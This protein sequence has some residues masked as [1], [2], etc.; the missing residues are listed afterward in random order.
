LYKEPKHRIRWLTAAELERLIA[1]LPER[2]RDATRFAVQTG[3]RQGNV[4]GLE[5]AQVDLERTTA[6]VHPDQAKARKA[7]GV[8]LSPEAVAILARQPRT[9]PLCF[10]GLNRPTNAVWKRALKK[11]SLED[12][13][14][15][16][17]RHTWA[18]WH[19]QQG[20]PLMALQ[21]L[22]GWESA[23]MVK[24]Y[25]HLGTSHLAAYVQGFGATK[26]TNA[27]Q[28]CQKNPLVTQVVDS[29]GPGWIRTNDQGIMSPLL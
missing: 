6:W 25:A 11:A 8:P 10:G 18:S 28:P 20:T 26:G 4:F 21:E 3:L 14:W 17:L 9:G 29:S 1:A 23:E 7:I 22:G 12:F 27:A 5:W 13:R 24:R 19:V 15:H 2:H 16:D